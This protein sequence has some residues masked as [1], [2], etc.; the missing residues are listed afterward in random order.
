[1]EELKQLIYSAQIPEYFKHSRII[2]LS[3]TKSPY[4]SVEDTKPIAIQLHVTKIAE[5]AILH[6]FKDKFP[7]FLATPGN[8]AGFQGR[9]EYITQ[10]F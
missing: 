3:K 6:Q 8:Q 2:V 5:K 4:P 1:M 7:E 9:D 10:P